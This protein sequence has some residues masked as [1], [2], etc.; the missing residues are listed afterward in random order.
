MASAVV[1]ESLSRIS[2]A[3]SAPAAASKQVLEAVRAAADE[4]SNTP[5]ITCRKSYVHDT[6]VTAFED[7]D[8]GTLR[9]D[10]E[11]LSLAVQARAIA[12][13][14]T[15]GS[16]D[17]GG[18]TLALVSDSNFKQRSRFR[19]LRCVSERTRN[20]FEAW[21]WAVGLHAPAAMTCKI[22]HLRLLAARCARVVQELCP[23][24]NRGRSATPREGSRAT[25]RGEQ[26]MPD[27]RRVRSRVRSKSSRKHARLVTTV[28]LETPG[29]PC[30]MVL[31]GF[32]SY[33]LPW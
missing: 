9:R 5:A 23:S 8:P 15:S 27:A 30:A 18:V 26:G 21:D 17:G 33:A 16:R 11:E 6:I 14:S 24:E 22:T 2:P 7:G 29:I 4:L 1:L 31:I 19:H 32:T 25:P 13:Q 28:V 10:H 3:A 20:S 12:W